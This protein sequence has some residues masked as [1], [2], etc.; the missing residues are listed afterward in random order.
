MPVQGIVIQLYTDSRKKQFVS[1][2]L[3]IFLI[4]LVFPEKI[5]HLFYKLQFYKNKDRGFTHGP[6]L[7]LIKRLVLRLLDYAN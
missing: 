4:K 5:F 7:Y 2:Y 6:Y 3:A 1:R